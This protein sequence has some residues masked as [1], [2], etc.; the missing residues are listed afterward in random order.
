MHLFFCWCSL[1]FHSPNAHARENAHTL[2]TYGR[3]IIVDKSSLE[4]LIVHVE[5]ILKQ[6][7]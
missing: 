2:I 5:S 7:E 3:T 4:F 1:N 6:I